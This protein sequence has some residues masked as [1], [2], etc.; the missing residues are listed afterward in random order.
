M[1]SVRG[2]VPPIRCSARAKGTGGRCRRYA[3]PGTAVCVMHGANSPNTVAKAEQRMTMAQLLRDDPRTPWE[4]VLDATHTADVIMRETK[5]KF[6]EGEE[7]GVELVDRLV[8]LTTYAHKLATVAIQ[9]K[10]ADH[11]AQARVE[12]LQSQTGI[13]AD[14]LTTAV[15]GVLDHLV[16]L[17]AIDQAYALQLRQWALDAAAAPAEAAG[18]RRDVELPTLPPVPRDATRVIEHDAGDDHDDGASVRDEDAGHDRAGV[19][20]QR[21]RPGWLRTVNDDASSES[22]ST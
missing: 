22:P 16:S 3:K 20:P 8:E 17:G 10:A 7:I 5:A 18:R 11:V 15:G 1:A 13:I 9:T 6:T 2:G 12:L 14:A 4:V 21:D 19:Q